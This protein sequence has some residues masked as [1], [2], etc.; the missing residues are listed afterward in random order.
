LGQVSWPRRQLLLPGEVTDVG[1]GEDA[2]FDHALQVGVCALIAGTMAVLVET[3]AAT[4]A[5]PRTRP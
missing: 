2:E 3:V 5:S 1:F 4:P